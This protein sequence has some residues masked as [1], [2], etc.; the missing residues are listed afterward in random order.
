MASNYIVPAHPSLLDVRRAY[1]RV[2]NKVHRGQIETNKAHEL[3]YLLGQLRGTVQAVDEQAR[4]LE[5]V[6]ADYTIEGDE[7]AQRQVLAQWLRVQLEEGRDLPWVIAHL[8]AMGQKQLQEA[9]PVRE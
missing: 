2:I 5:A 6:D 3:G 8:E 7:D 4:A 1:A 9:G